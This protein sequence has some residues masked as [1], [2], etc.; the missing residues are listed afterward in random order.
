[1]PTDHPIP[2]D[3]VC[4]CVCVYVPLMCPDYPLCAQPSMVSVCLHIIPPSVSSAPTSV[5]RW[6]D[7][8][9]L[10]MQCKDSHCPRFATLMTFPHSALHRLILRG[11]HS[12]N[13]DFS[14][15][16]NDHQPALPWPADLEV[17]SVSYS[18]RFWSALKEATLPW[19]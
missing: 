14:S 16:A 19:Y 8:H 6:P 7:N 9:S 17:T 15:G 2:S 5:P 3:Q 1:M 12:G 4:Q 11:A 18:L 13:D 10:A